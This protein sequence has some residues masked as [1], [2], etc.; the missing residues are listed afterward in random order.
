MEA[1]ETIGGMFKDMKQEYI[2]HT[3]NVRLL[4]V[5]VE[6]LQVLELLIEDIDIHEVTRKL[7]TYSDSLSFLNQSTN[8]PNNSKL[9]A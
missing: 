4:L 9:A 5:I 6:V 3:L 7:I 8:S 2:E 1:Y